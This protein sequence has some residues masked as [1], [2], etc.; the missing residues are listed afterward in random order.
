MYMRLF[1]LFLFF[2][3]LSV[4]G[5]AQLFLN[6]FLSSN[7]N[8]LADEDRD[9]SD[10]VEIYNAGS[11]NIDLSGYS[12]SDD[13]DFPRK[14]VFPQIYIQ[15]MGHVLVFASGK[16]RRNPPISWQTIIDRGDEW[17]YLVPA[18]DL[19]PAWFGTGY[20]DSS[21]GND[22]SGFGYGDGDDS[23]ELGPVI[24]VFIRKTF[25]LADPG[26]LDS[27]VLSVDYDDAFVAYL[28]GHEVARSN[29]GSPGEVT[30]FHQP[31]AANHEAA[32]FQG[33]VP[34]YFPIAS[35][36]DQLLEGQNL[37]AI[38]VHNL[39]AGSTDLSLIPFLSIGRINGGESGI[40]P[41][42]DFSTSGSLHASFKLDSDGETLCLFDPS[43]ELIDSVRAISLPADVA[44][45]RGP[46]GS[47]TWYYYDHPTPGTPNTS[48]GKAHL[49]AVPVSM[50]PPG[51]IHPGGITVTLAG[52]G[53]NDSIYYTT[54]GSV[55]DGS[56]ALYTAPIYI[57][58]SQVIR[59][60][61]MADSA[62]PGPV[63]SHT[64]I[65]GIDHDVPIVSL[66]T[67]PDNLWD[68]ET[69]IFAYGPHAQP[70]Y[71]YFNANF[72][73]DWERPVH[74][75]YFD[76]EGVRQIDQDAGMKVFGAWSR[77]VEQKSLA[78][79]ARKG[80]GRGSFSYPFF[81]DKPIDSF[82][83]VVLRNSGNDNLGLQFQDCFMTGLTRDMEV[84][85]QSFQP[86]A[87]Y[88]NGG[89]WG[90]L[91]IREKIS[92]HFI[93]SNHHI[94][95]DSVN[96]LET[97]GYPVHGSNARYME[98]TSYLNETPTL[99]QESDFALVAAEVDLDNFIQYQLTQ[100]YLNN[101]DWPANNIKFWNSRLAASK[102]R[103][104]IYDTD[105][106]FGLWNTEDYKLNTL[107]FALATDGPPWPNPPWSTLF[108]RRMVTNPAFRNNFI[109][110]YCDRLNLDFHP[111]RIASDLDSLKQ[112]Y[113][114]EMVHTFNRWWGNIDTWQWQIDN[115]KVFGNYRPSYCRQHMQDIFNLGDQLTVQIT[116]PDQGGYVELNTIRPKA[117]PFTGIYFRNIPIRLKAIPKPGYK[118]VQWTG[119]VYGNRPDITYNMSAAGEFRAVFT[120]AAPEEQSVVINEINYQS[121]PERDTKDWI[122][123]VNS[124]VATV[125]LGGWL[126][127]DGDMDSGYVFPSNTWLAPGDFIVI[128]RNKERFRYFNPET[129]NLTGELPFGLSSSGE[130]LL[131]YNVNR[132]LMDVV[133]YQVQT[134]WPTQA[135]GTGATIE[136]IHPD[137]DNGKGENWKANLIGGTPGSVNSM[138]EDTGEVP[139]PEGLNPVLD[140]FPNPFSDYSTIRFEVPANG[141]YRLEVV[142]MHGRLVALLADHYLEAG[143]Y[144][145]DW[146]GNEESGASSGAGIYLVRLT[147]NKNL[148]SRKIVKLP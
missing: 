131:L 57:A 42:L 92:E 7:A 114:N 2:A 118:F 30:P 12:L 105:F 16:N 109:I 120:R 38:Q 39:N 8:G 47:S 51:G 113:R 78:L 126:L 112:L 115:R 71:P 10:W 69:G 143:A 21:W 103:W 104:I 41:W 141:H 66:S 80:Y 99:Q 52:A 119:S 63:A 72:W 68:F 91:N 148:A 100:I 70:D 54:D 138:T 14:W 101:R 144:W 50:S 31:A 3:L 11:T 87:V 64:Y 53:E 19:G 89:Y 94:P 142:D 46:E 32:L 111:S 67:D 139:L 102:W 6:E 95:A 84:D 136:L 77:A 9:Y 37:L 74:V 110:Q 140:C 40:S 49:L 25:A 129:E 65:T 106:G 56:D 147:G 26:S 24:S 28:N 122:E 18:S 97:S 135:L 73:M 45:G 81:A 79:F 62:L 35:P 128:C 90:L 13:P 124:G 4:P 58:G 44:Y 5:R 61:V 75:E 133:N 20:D 27:L 17:R 48:Q 107:E 108:L 36:E 137:A 86:A 83:S 59:A 29:I 33:G 55:P 125:D 82:E 76:H 116:V 145:I 22:P 121:S 93:A 34:E 117:Y 43:G 15:P 23:T 123:L 85:R 88:I 134:P 127:T 60:R 98:L 146:S 130:S 96:L 132:Q 1:T